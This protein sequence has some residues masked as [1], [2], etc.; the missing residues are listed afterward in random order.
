M[1]QNNER[2]SGNVRANPA[3]SHF[4]EQGKLSAS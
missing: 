2:V 3:D 4:G 1:H